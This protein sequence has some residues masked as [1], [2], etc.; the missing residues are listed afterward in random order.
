MKDHLTISVHFPTKQGYIG[1][2]CNNPQCGQY[3]K[4]CESTVQDT[5]YCPYCGDSFD[6]Q[7]LLTKEQTEHVNK[8]VKQ[9]ALDLV[10]NELNN[11]LK[12]TFGSHSARKS[13]LSY[14]PSSFRKRNINPTYEEREVDSELHCAICNTKFQVYGV[15]GFCPGCK[16]ENVLVYDANIK[17]IEAEIASSPNPDRQLRHAYNDLVSTFENICTRKSSRITNETGHFQVLFEARKYFKKHAQIDIFDKL[18]N[19]QLLT[20]RRLFQKRHLY[21]HSD[22][23][24]NDKYIKMIPE[25]S[26]LLGQKAELSLDEFREAAAALYIAIG[27]LVKR[28]E[29][30]G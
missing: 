30:K 9:E 1:R 11:M 28:V 13:G 16:E 24:I 23:T 4:V 19:K 6:N 2:A 17:I 21:V 14:K 26:K 20:L 29:R 10:H 22:G 5:M 18:D 12:K 15:F 3:F 27:D 25:D 7:E 8:V